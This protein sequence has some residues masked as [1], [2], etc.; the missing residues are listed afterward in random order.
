MEWLSTLS[1]ATDWLANLS[2]ST[3]WLIRLPFSDPQLWASLLTLTVMEIVLGID[4]LIFI[5]ILANRLP[6]HQQGQARRI[7]LLLALGLRLGLLASIAWIMRLTTPVFEVFDHSFSWR[8][9]I[10]IAGGLFLVYKGTAEI[11][12]RIEGEAPHTAAGAAAQSF[13]GI[14]AQIVVIDVVFSLDSVITAVGMASELAVMMAAVVISIGVMMVASGPVAAFVNRHP[15]VKMLALSF[16]LLIGTMLVA[17]G[18]GMHVPKGYIYAAIGFSAL[19]EAL[20][21]VASRRRTVPA[22]EVSRPPA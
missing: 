17:D 18:F 11:H 16:L 22:K 5:A 7:G 13:F 2:F 12:E 4:N 8:D 3:D 9:V 21:Q 14:V 19:V 10:L 1:L 6:E 15:T 20:N